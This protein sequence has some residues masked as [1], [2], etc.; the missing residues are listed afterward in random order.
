MVILF[1]LVVELLA[2]EADRRKLHAGAWERPPE[3]AAAFPSCLRVLVWTP[4]FERC[5]RMNEFTSP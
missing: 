4:F 3:E 2:M 1:L 5:S